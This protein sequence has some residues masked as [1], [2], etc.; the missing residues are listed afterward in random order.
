M[1]RTPSLRLLAF[2]TMVALGS[3]CS[4]FKSSRHINVAPFAENTVAMIG[5]VQ[6]ATKPIVWV[7][8]KKYEDLQTIEDVREGFAPARTLMRG[9]ALYST[10]IVSIYESNLPESRK[11]AEL[12]HYLDG[13]IRERIQSDPMAQQ[14]FTAGRL[15]TAVA[16]ARKSSTFLGA[17]GAA[18]PVVSAALSFGNDVYD[19][20]DIRIEIAADDIDHRIETEW[21]PLKTQVAELTDLELRAIREYTLLARYRLGD[22]ATLD[23]LRSLDPA[24]TS[25]IPTGKPPSATALDATEKRL[26]SNIDTV[27]GLRAHLDKEYEIYQAEQRE[28]DTLRSQS[29]EAARLGRIT[30]ILWA[31]SHRN[32]AGGVAVPAQIDLM[33]MFRSAAGRAANLVP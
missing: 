16:E 10:Q 33:G 20:V 6:R 29:Q 27:N 21:A 11:V 30:L 28:L 26:L 23:T 1:C 7:Y 12:A 8:L 4:S 22:A 31:R 14:F 18:Q 5:E 24:V 32:L 15:D 25:A 19:S 17:L 2:V 3:G 13:A 9:V